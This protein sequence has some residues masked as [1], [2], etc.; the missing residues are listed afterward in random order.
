MQTIAAKDITAPTYVHFQVV[1]QGMLRVMTEI[2][3]SEGFEVRDSTNDFAAFTIEVLGPPERTSSWTTF[4]L[5]ND[6]MH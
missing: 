3:T 4:S 5:A 1:R 6:P 2:L